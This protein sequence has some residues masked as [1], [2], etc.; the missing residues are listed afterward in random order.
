ML[1]NGCAQ[2]APHRP[3][4]DSLVY[5]RHLLNLTR[6]RTKHSDHVAGWAN[7]S[8]PMA[9]TSQISPYGLGNTKQERYL[10]KTH[11]AAVK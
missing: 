5:Q 9:M 2:G 4:L 7:T 6:I 8:T 3:P 11:G 10:L 1:P